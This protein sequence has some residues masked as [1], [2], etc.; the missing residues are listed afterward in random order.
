MGIQCALCHSTTDDAIAP[1][2]GRR[3][4]GW[5]NRD[6]NVGAIMSSAP[7]LSFFAELFG[8]TEEQ[9]RE[10]LL[11]W[12]P[13]KFDAILPLDGKGFRPDGKTAA[14]LIP[15]AFGLAGVNL[16][17]WTGWG[18]V[19]YW[20]A[21]VANLE[22][23]GK[24]V[25]LDARLNDAEKFPVAAAHPELFGE[26][27]DEVD[28]ITPALPALHLYQL[29][30]K[31]PSPPE[32]TFDREAA[33]RGRA[34]FSGK[35]RCACCHVPPIYTDPGFNMHSPEEIGIDSFQADRSPDEMYRT[36]PLAGLWT[37]QKGGFYHDGRFPTLL[38]VVNH[39]ESVRNMG[40]TEAEKQDLIQY[41]LSL[42]AELE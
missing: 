30:L 6:L 25:F 20:N 3:L 2:V 12:G 8:L 32:D 4:D 26:K 41:L 7:D 22:M 37:H 11:A 10:V 13:G 34:L 27:R 28:L 40:L 23:R 15:P 31:A 35:A 16:H 38:E 39:Y 5:A 14:V 33:I 21:F 9:V 1:G 24:G 36:S 29:S 42:P 19:P 17:T 18:S